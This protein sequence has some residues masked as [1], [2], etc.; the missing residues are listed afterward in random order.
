MKN[1]LQ[2]WHDWKTI[3]LFN[4]TSPYVFP[5]FSIL[6]HTFPHPLK[7]TG[8]IAQIGMDHLLQNGQLTLALLQVLLAGLW[9]RKSECTT[10]VCWQPSISFFRLGYDDGSTRFQP[11]LQMVGEWC[12]ACWLKRICIS[13]LM[14][15]SLQAQFVLVDPNLISVPTSQQK[16]SVHFTARIMERPRHGGSGGLIQMQHLDLWLQN[17][18]K[19]CENRYIHG[20]WVCPNS[21]RELPLFK[22]ICKCQR[23]WGKWS[24]S[25]KP[26]IFFGLL[27]DFFRW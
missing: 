4:D 2:L 7:A 9:T 21:T 20:K 22:Y 13:A 15:L 6:F 8:P 5:Y 14:S 26:L 25:D 12:L 17:I 10:P 27:H 16:H 1:I 11:V 3:L 23:R 18:P 19:L 24:S